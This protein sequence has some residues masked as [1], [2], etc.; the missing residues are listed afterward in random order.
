MANKLFGRVTITVSG[1]TLNTFKGSTLDIGGIKRTPQPGSNTADA[2]TEELMPSK[3]ECEVQM[4][5]SLSVAALGQVVDATI[6]F[7]CDTGQKFLIIGGYAAEPPVLT[8]GDGKC[9]CVFQGP[10]AEEVA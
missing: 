6:Q 3:V 7:D 4:D 9:K 5:G 8:E 2:Y 1:L 10:P